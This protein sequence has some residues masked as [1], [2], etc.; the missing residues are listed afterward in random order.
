MDNFKATLTFQ[1]TVELRRV[2]LGE[3]ASV[4]VN[5]HLLGVTDPVEVLHF[6]AG[7]EDGELAS[8]DLQLLEGFG[9]R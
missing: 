6:L 8:L 9:T 2:G 5:H 4:Y 1:V 7:V 3:W